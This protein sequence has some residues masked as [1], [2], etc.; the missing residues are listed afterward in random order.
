MSV[1]VIGGDHL[2]GIEKN[3][4]AMG[5]TEL[6]HI[7]GRKSPGKRIGFPRETAFVLVFTD[8]VNHNTAQTVKTI[9]KSQAIPMIFAKR[10]WSS[11]EEKLQVSWFGNNGQ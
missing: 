3:L 1:V 4:Y 10:S 5:V 11:V 6:I 8:Y 2:G 7:S 9:A